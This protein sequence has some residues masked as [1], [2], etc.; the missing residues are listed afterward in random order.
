[1]FKRFA[2][3]QNTKTPG[4]PHSQGEQG[5]SL[6]SVLIIM[7]IVLMAILIIAN[8]RVNH[9]TTQK[10]IKLK[11]S[12]ADINQALVNDIVNLVH[13][14]ISATAPCLSVSTIAVNINAGK[15]VNASTPSYIF[16]KALPVNVSTW[17]KAHVDAAARCVTPRIPSNGNS[18]ADNRIYFCIRLGQDATAPKDSIMNSSLAFAE[19]AVEMIDLQTQQAISCDNYSKKKIDPKDGSAGMAV[20]MAL[21]WQAQT[22]NRT[23]FSQKALSYIANQN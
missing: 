2:T 13:T 9:Q 1:M 6:I 15:V 23:N 22:G 20:T 5:F 19:V 21:Y 11:Q 3:K 14:N 7:G 18:D 16:T 8:S 10:A 17:P 4:S 12:Y